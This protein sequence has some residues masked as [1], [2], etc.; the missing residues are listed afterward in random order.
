MNY[1]KQYISKLGEET[2]FISSNLEKVLRLLDVLK[3]IFV[4][5]SFS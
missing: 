5:S 2:N 1:S 4:N 3:F